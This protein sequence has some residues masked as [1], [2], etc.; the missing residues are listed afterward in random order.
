MTTIGAIR[1]DAWTGGPI[2]TQVERTLSP[3]QYQDRAPWF[4]QPLAPDQLSIHADQSIMDQEILYAADAGLDYW[5]FVLYA[6]G[7]SME[8][9]LDH[10]LASPHNTRLNFS[11]I[12]HSSFSVP[13]AQWPAERDRTL[14]LLKHT[15]YQTVLNNRPLVYAFAMGDGDK[16]PRARFTEF[17][18]AARAQGTDPYMVYMGWNPAADYAAQSP[19]G[20]HAVSAY[21]H[22][23]NH[24]TFNQLV[25]NLESGPWQSAL[26]TN[27][28]YIPIVT[29]G[30]NKQ[31]RKDHPV[32]WELNHGYHKDTLFTPPATPDEIAHHLARAIAFTQQNPQIN[33]ANTL[34]LYAWNEHDE[35]GW[36][37][38]TLNPTNPNTPNTSR[39]DAIKKVLKS[40]LRSKLE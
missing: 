20:F 25:E 33:P 38:P 21:A 40:T 18:T 24:P 28:P 34:L 7:T 32:A 1:W 5:A 37:T 19:L 2:T 3:R 36:L 31:P 6:R 35:G 30:W 12:L 16:F 26:K 9:A 27:T 11:L 22:P 14:A 23:G 10:Y 8:V 29:T 17:L 39:L 15:A 13:D 4:A